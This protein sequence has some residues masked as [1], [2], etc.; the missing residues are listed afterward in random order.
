MGASSKVKAF[1]FQNTT[2][3]RQA[4]DWEKKY[5]PVKY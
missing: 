2:K 3:E 1:A 5:L 4:I